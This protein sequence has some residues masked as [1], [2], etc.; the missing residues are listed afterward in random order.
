M[1]YF[2]NFP[3]PGCGI[4]RAHFALLRFDF[5]QAYHYHPLFFIAIP[6]ILYVPHRN[7]LKRKLSI[8]AEII[9]IIILSILFLMVYLIRIYNKSI[10]DLI[11]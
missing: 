6:I 1:Y 8:K 5:K 7:V 3:C 4:T 11:L 2:F 9:S 10:F